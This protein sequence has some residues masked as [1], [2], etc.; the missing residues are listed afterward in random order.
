MDILAALD[1]MKSMKHAIDLCSV[2]LFSRPKKTRRRG[3]NLAIRALYK[4]KYVKRIHDEDIEDDEDDFGPGSSSADIKRQKTTHTGGPGKP[5][6]SLT[7]ASLPD[8]SDT[9]GGVRATERSEIAVQML[10]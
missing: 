9:Q 3:M 8:S 2:S 1:E 10:Y 6:D 4:D 7:K 5:T